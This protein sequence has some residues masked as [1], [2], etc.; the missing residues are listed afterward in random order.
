MIGSSHFILLCQNTEGPVCLLINFMIGLFVC[1]KNLDG[2][3]L[4]IALN[5]Q[6]ILRRTDII[7]CWVF[8]PRNHSKSLWLMFAL[9]SFSGG[10]WFPAFRSR[11][12]SAGGHP[13]VTLFLGK[14]YMP[15]PC[16]ISASMYLL[17]AYRN[18][19]FLCRPCNLQPCRPHLLLLGTSLANCSGFSA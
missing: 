18:T 3:F 19:Q 4:G 16:Y 6:I 2:I 10:L 15:L 12:C 17:L 14:L 8:Q 1:T 13:S 9:T 7:D 5:L 11:T